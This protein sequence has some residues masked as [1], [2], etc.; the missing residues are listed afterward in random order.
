[1]NIVF[2]HIPKT[3]G[4][5]IHSVLINQYGRENV[6][7]VRVNAQF[8]NYNFA[9][10][11]NYKVYSG[12]LD[13]EKLDFVRDPKVIFTI[14]R[15]PLERLSSFYLYLKRKAEGLPDDVLNRPD[16]RGLYLAKNL[17]VD[18]YFCKADLP[19]RGFIDN[20]YDN[21]YTY[22]FA[23]R[24]YDSRPEMKR[25]LKDQVD[26]NQT[27]LKRAVDNA[28]YIDLIGD[29]DHLDVFEERFAEK[30]GTTLPFASRKINVNPDQRKQTRYEMLCELNPSE[31]TKDK[32][33]AFIDLDNQLYKAI[34]FVK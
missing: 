25:L 30:V 14:L 20:H 33:A 16:H 11:Q 12:H 18:E 8:D 2:L 26:Y 21:F 31:A 29:I 23:G 6:C 4:Q 13:W 28:R 1:M 19:E 34:D 9:D 24:R 10:L 5:S 7:P 27:L 22:F 3:A 15:D 17:S 32:I